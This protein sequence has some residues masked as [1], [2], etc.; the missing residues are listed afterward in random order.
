MKHCKLFVLLLCLSAVVAIPP[1]EAKRMIVKTI[2]RRAVKPSLG[3][4]VTAVLARLNAKASCHHRS[5]STVSKNCLVAYL[6]SPTDGLVSQFCGW[7]RRTNKPVLQH[8]AGVFD[9]TAITNVMMPAV[10]ELSTRWRDA[11]K[12]GEIFD[13]QLDTEAI[14]ESLHQHHKEPSESF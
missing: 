12:R 10:L 2:R 3:Q 1:A 8:L 11:K 4:D 6:A 5:Q 13:G 9:I 14:N 7:D